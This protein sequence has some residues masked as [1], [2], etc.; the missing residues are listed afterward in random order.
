ML[1]IHWPHHVACGLLVPQPGIEPASLALEAWSFNHWIAR[2][3][4]LCFEL[5]FIF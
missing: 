2:E 5:L 3:V 4:L 1:F